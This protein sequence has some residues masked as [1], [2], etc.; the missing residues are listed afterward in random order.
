MERRAGG[1]G[2]KQQAQQEG[3]SGS[4]DHRVPSSLGGCGS[5]VKKLQPTPLIHDASHM[6]FNPDVFT[7]LPPPLLTCTSSRCAAAAERALP[8]S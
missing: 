3:M 5:V 2:G 4:R 1:A 8:K 6:C 7:P